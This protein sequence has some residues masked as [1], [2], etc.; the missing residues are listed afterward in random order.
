MPV[1]VRGAQGQCQLGQLEGGTERAR[2]AFD[3]REVVEGSSLGRTVTELARELHTAA[4]VIACRTQVPRAPGDHAEDV[5]RL[6]L[7]PAILRRLGQRE[8]LHR[9]LDGPYAMTG[10][11]Q[12][13]AEIGDDAR[14]QAEVVVRRRRQRRGEP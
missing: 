13:E 12:R 8:C 9:E 5:V 1:A 2:V 11:V 10:E 3:E 7:R 4:E 14:P 6:G